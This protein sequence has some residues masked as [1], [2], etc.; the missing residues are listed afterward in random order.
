MK[1]NYMKNESGLVTVIALLMVGMLTLIGIAA[2]STSDDEVAIAG[3]EMHDIKAFYAAEAGL[4][5]ATA[6]I[7]TVYDST[8]IPPAF[9]P[10]G[11]LNLEEYGVTYSTTDDGVPVP[12]VLTNGP[13]TGLNAMTKSFTITSTSHESN[14]RSGVQMSQVFEAA[15]VPLFQFAVFYEPD[16]EIAPGPDMDLIGRVHTNGDLYL[17]AGNT[18]KIESYVTAAGDIMHGRKG[19]GGVSSGDVL[20]K[21]ID[22]NFVSMQEAG[23]WLDAKDD[24][25]LDSS[26][27]KWKG[28]VQDASHGQEKL[29]V[30]ITGGGN[31]HKLIEPAAGNPD[32]Y[33]LKSSLK[34]IDGVW[35]QK[36]GGVWQDVTAGM[37]AAGVVSFDANKFYDGREGA[38][39]DVV[40]LDMDALYSSSYAPDNG[41]IYFSQEQ[42]P[43][44]FRD[45]PALRLVNGEELDEGLTIASENPVYTIG[46]YNSVDKKPASI[47]AD[48]V[49][50]LSSAWDDSKG[51]DDKSTRPAVATTVNVSYLTGN[52]ETTDANYNGG[53]ENLPRFLEVWSGKNFTWAGSAVNLWNSVQANGDWTG[54]V[55]SP[56]IRDWAYDTDLDDPNNMP[57]G[58]P[59]VR[60]FQRTGWRQEHVGFSQIHE[61][62]D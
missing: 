19:A 20:I 40:E 4:E 29:A 60:I 17:Q 38:N 12:S 35:T 37:T 62:A 36:I 46:D 34:C 18:L 15:L 6:L 26:I 16:L 59:A 41:L 23:G 44:N 25:W 50:F 51:A 56:P 39:V 13:L 31:P 21:D 5:A 57:P 22:G 43:A 9:L 8:G 49:T 58:T 61:I 42:T 2:I 33:E 24:Y 28:T 30:P 47:L 1:Y 48:A 52:V 14:S 10:A 7:E 54:A 3:N 45:F 53:F 32:S 55:Y 11:A 27:Y